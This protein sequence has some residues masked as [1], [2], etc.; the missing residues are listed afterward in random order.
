MMVLSRWRV[1]ETGSITLPN[2]RDIGAVATADADGRSVRVYS[3]HLSATYRASVEHA[4]E[5]AKA[6]DREARRI[7]GLASAGKTPV[8]VAGDLNTTQGSAPYARLARG[9][10]DAALALGKPSPTFPRALPAVRLDHVFV[11]KL[12]RPVRVVTKRG[13]SDHLMVVVDVAWEK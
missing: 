5:A 7:A 11:S 4:A 10:T 2:S 1:L 13:A 3:V 9:R 8:I 12:L 6:R